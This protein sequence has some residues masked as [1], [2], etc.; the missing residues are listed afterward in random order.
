MM[1]PRPFAPRVQTAR[2]RIDQKRAGK[3]RRRVVRGSGTAGEQG[4]RRPLSAPPPSRAP[5]AGIRLYTA[6]GAEEKDIARR[7]WD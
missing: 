5:V 2:D 7:M 3:T 6:A 1:P 4:G